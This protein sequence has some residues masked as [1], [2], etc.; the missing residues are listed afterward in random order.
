M[1]FKKWILPALL[2][3]VI[4]GYIVYRQF[5]VAPTT[6]QS[7]NNQTSASNETINPGQNQTPT[8][9]PPPTTQTGYK[10]GQYTGIVASS[11]YGDTQVQVTIS[12]GKITA[13]EMLQTPSG[14]GHTQQVAAMS[15]PVLKSETIAAQSANVNI[16]SGAT[17]NSQ[18][19]IQSLQSALSQAS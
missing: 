15:Y 19:F 14:P 18:A 12:G 11:V 17:Q 5:S 1:D 3:I 10:D 13:V 4:V 2:V 9:T 7:N 16:V 8:Q 6:S